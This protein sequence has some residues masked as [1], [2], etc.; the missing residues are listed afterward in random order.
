[1]FQSPLPAS[2]GIWNVLP[3]DGEIIKSPFSIDVHPS[4]QLVVLHDQIRSELRKI[5]IG[6]FYRS[7]LE[8]LS[9]PLVPT[10]DELKSKD[11]VE[12]RQ[13]DHFIRGC[14][15]SS[16][17][18]LKIVSFFDQLYPRSADFAVRRTISA[19]SCCRA[20]LA[21]NLTFERGPQLRRR[22][23]C[24]A[25]SS[26]L[27]SLFNALLKA[28]YN[29]PDDG[30]LFDMATGEYLPHDVV[31]PS[32]I[33]LYRWRRWI[34]H[35]TSFKDV[36]D[37]RNGLLL[38]KPVEWAFNRAKLCINVNSTGE[39]AF[40]LLDKDLYDVKLIERLVSPEVAAI[41]LGVR[42][43]LET[44]FGDLDREPVQFPAGSMMRP[45][46]QLL[47]LHAIAAWVE[48]QS[49]T[50]NTKILVPECNA[51]DEEVINIRLNM[52]IEAWRNRVVEGGG[53]V[54]KS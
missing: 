42:R 12:L 22:Y 31:K 27:H 15:S 33:F 23:S 38:Y 40:Q 46:E 7:S 11:P 41:L 9:L 28:E 2:R 14:I 26:G 50:P 43:G 1:M 51:S 10:L 8:I 20:R 54:S 37:V 6:G 3:V 13:E 5:F 4:A 48:S 16:G 32:H 45:S 25:Q 44:T 18:L 17:C 53:P 52:I 36:N 24:F 47:G 34:S 29:Q 21:H 49:N 39:I 19:R 35:Y 30:D